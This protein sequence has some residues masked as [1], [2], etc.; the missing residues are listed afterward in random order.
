MEIERRTSS[1]RITKLEKNEVFVFGS[2]LEGNHESGAARTAFLRWGAK[3][4]IA[5]GHE[6]QSYAIPTREDVDGTK[7]DKNTIQESVDRFI[8]YC[9]Q[10]PELDF[11]VVCIGCGSAGFEVDDIAPMFEKALEVDNILL[12][13][14]F[15]DYLTHD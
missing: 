2:N 10:H 12:S 11:H 13:T 15:T 6:G 7:L 4:G 1:S 3:E 5:E 9:K 8:D 14:T